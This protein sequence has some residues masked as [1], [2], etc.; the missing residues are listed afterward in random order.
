MEVQI[1]PWEGAVMRGKG[2]SHCNVQ[3]HSAITC[4]K[5]AEP[6]VMPFVLWAQ[7]CPRNQVRVRQ[8]PDARMRRGNFGERVARCKIQ[9]LS[10]VSCAEMAKPIKLPF[11]LWTRV[12]RMKFNQIRQVA[13]MCPH[14]RAHWRHLA[15][16]TEVSACGGDE[17][18][19]QITLTTCSVVGSVHQMKLAVARTLIGLSIISFAVPTRCHPHAFYVNHDVIKNIKHEQ[20]CINIIFINLIFDVWN[21]ENTAV[22]L[23]IDF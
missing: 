23:F 4:A 6:I 3:G 14:G 11:G 17:V 9:G 22:L 12:D 5:T 16:T 18:L 2:A 8:G 21:A 10:A 19:C 7:N 15:N 13:P 1:P 20:Y